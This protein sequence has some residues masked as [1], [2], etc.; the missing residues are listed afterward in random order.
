MF[1]MNANKK[2][3]LPEYEYDMEVDLKDPTKLRAMKEKVETRIHQLKELLRDGGDKQLFDQSQ[4]LLHG[5]L[6]MQKVMQRCNRKM[7]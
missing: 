6:A 1:E 4:T 3:P 7:F 2:T 5:Y